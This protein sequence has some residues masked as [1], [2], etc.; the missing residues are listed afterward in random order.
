[1]GSELWDG[2][3][4]IWP[5]NLKD[6]VFGFS[7]EKFERLLKENLFAK[8]IMRSAVGFVDV[9]GSWI[10]AF[11]SLK[12][13]D[14]GLPMFELNSSHATLI[15]APYDWRKSIVH[16]A[17]AVASAIK[18]AIALHGDDVRIHI[19]AHSMGGLVA[20]YFLDSGAY[21][22]SDGVE[23]VETFL[24]FGS[25]HRG[26][27]VA[28]AGAIGLETAKFLS[29]EQSSRLANDPALRGLYDLFP[30]PGSSTFWE[31]GA[32]D[33]RLNPR[34][35]WDPTI[36]A[37]L[38]LNE[39]TLAASR[40]TLSEITAPHPGPRRFLFVGN[41][42]KTVTHFLLQG[43]RVS[44]V[45][46]KDGG[47]G[48]VN[49]QGSILEN[50]QI[51]FVDKNHMSLIESRD[52]RS[53][54]QD[55]FNADGILPMDPETRV[56]MTVSDLILAS[57]APFEIALTLEG[58]SNELDGSLF[59]QRAVAGRDA[60][61]ISESD[62]STDQRIMEQTVRYSGPD[63]LSLHVNIESLGGPGV[64]RPVFMTNDDKPREFV[65]PA[66]LVTLDS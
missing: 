29:S 25:P 61:G 56:V 1:M 26:A 55:I 2:D 3:G 65:G 52:T 34:E 42:L 31:S 47:D 64:Y 48:T 53:A 40:Q 17:Q 38:G 23:N 4:R 9:Y 22:V 12:S 7:E 50:H 32:Q 66:F 28:L 39:E 24:T 13:R 60:V 51:R 41:R 18:R 44:P 57:K 43:R 59:F 6:A 20:R 21:G 46:T 8:N 30:Q 49:L 35:L 36:A 16:G 15:L 10:S 58:P 33:T 5:G 27:P 14:T 62:F 54:L 63:L 37:L 11:E 19:A 45:A